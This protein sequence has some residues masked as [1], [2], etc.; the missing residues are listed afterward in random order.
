[1]RTNV[2]S[3]VSRPLTHEGVAA[4]ILNPIQQ[5]RRSVM[6]CMLFEDQFYVDGVSVADRIVEEVNTILKRYPEEGPSIVAN[7]AHEARTSGNLR[8]APLWLVTAL[9]RANTA[10]TRAVVAGAIFHV[11]QRPDELAELVAMYWKDGKK[12]LPRQVRMGLGLAFQ[13]FDRYSLSKYANRDGAVRMRD[14]LFLSHAKPKDDEQ[15]LLWKELAEDI[16]KA[17]ENTWEVQL[18]AG[19]DKKLA[20]TNLL[21][22]NSLGALALLRNLR[23]MIEA[24]VDL[25]LIRGALKTMKTYRVLPFRF[26]SAARY[27]PN[28]ESDLEMAMFRSLAEMPKLEGRTI[29]I[30]DNSGSMYGTKVSEKSDIDRSDAACALAMLLRE[31]CSEIRILSFSDRAAEVP[32]RR[33]FAL[34]DSIQKAVSVSGTNTENALALARSRGYDRI[35]VLTDEQSAQAVSKPMENSLAYFINVA[36]YQNGIGYGSWTHLD[37]WSESIVSYIQA[38]ESDSSK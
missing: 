22:E 14:V 36:S 2:A 34:R 24:G 31:V 20:F 5:L 35:I 13:K 30:V 21:A 19:K 8:H 17:P 11:I 18:S 23:N 16:L 15:A 6:A 4:S 27:A 7:I 29:L 3:P 1:M 26:I 38:I 33:G 37:G 32:P 12:M 10:A 28:L 25:D 9:I